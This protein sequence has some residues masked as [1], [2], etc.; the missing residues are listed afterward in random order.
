M[1]DFKLAYQKTIYGNEGGYNPGIGERETYEGIDRGANPDWSGWKVIDAAK[2]ANPGLN[3][4]QLNLLF[5]QNFT[6][7]ANIQEF[8]KANY[9]DVLNLDHV[10]DQVLADNLF[11]C[12]VNQGEGLARKLMQAACNSVNLANHSPLHMLTVDRI[13]GPATLATFNSLPA[14]QLNAE[15]NAMRWWSYQQD[16]GFAEWGAVWKKR[17]EDYPS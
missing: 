17:L 13:I 3:I 12:S 10:N 9:W 8:Y 7:Q 4:H 5:A 2:A 6:L 11:D 14:A 16:A 1:A 15:L